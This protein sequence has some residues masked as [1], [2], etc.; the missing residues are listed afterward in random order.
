M[1]R[2][3]IVIGHLVSSKVLEVDKAKV[4]VI[5]DLVVAYD[6]R[7]H[8]G[9]TLRRQRSRHPRASSPLDR[10]RRRMPTFTTLSED[11]ISPPQ[12]SSSSRAREVIV[13][14]FPLFR[15]FVARMCLSGPL[16]IFFSLLGLVG[17]FPCF[18]TLA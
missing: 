3:G 12:T 4:E 9:M 2:E 16:H 10:R 11:F 15:I 1:V 8:Q 7:R 5:Q 6:P 13:L 18:G 17:G 14:S